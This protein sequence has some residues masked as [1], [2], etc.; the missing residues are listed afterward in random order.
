MAAEIRKDQAVTS[1][2][3]LSRGVPEFVIQRK[4]MEQHDGRTGTEDFIGDLR[5]AAGEAFHGEELEREI[6]GWSLVDP[7]EL[8]RV[9]APRA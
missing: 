7:S 6:M 3:G 1:E 8:K 9:L 5:I 2:K 4:R